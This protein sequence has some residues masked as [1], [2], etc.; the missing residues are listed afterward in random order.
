MSDDS[1]VVKGAAQEAVA[2]QTMAT[3]PRDGTVVLLHWG[4]DHV[5]PGWWNAPCSPVQN[6]DGTW[7]TDTGGFPW[8]FFDLRDGTTFVNHAADTEYG[9][10][11]WSVYAAPVA[12]APTYG[13]PFST[14]QRVVRAL[15]QFGVAT[16]ESQEEQ[17]ARA[18]ELIHW[19]CDEVPKSFSSTP[20]A[21]GIDLEQFR[22]AVQGWRDSASNEQA[23]GLISMAEWLVIADRA[24][25]LLALIDASHKGE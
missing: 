16:P 23:D 24:D 20:A 6:G 8:A 2:R 4:E 1:N 17:A 5:S 14:V 21:P 7:P 22:E 13:V 9:P 11:H 25:R 19:L 12:A 18:V 10:T 3:C 15:T